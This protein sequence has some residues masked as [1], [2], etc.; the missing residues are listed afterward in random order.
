MA[1]SS[2]ESR[3]QALQEWLFDEGP[4]KRHI[5]PFHEAAGSNPRDAFDD[6]EY[7]KRQGHA[8]VE[9]H[10]GGVNYAELTV[11]G[12]VHVEQL[13]ERRADLPMRNQAC[14]REI[15][16]WLY[17]IGARGESG[18]SPTWEE[19]CLDPQADYL[20]SSFTPEEVEENAGWLYD[21]KLIDGPTVDA[22]LGPI[23]PHLTIRGIDS[24]ERATGDP[25][26][27]TRGALSSPPTR[28]THINV[29]GGYVQ[30]STG[31]H[32]TQQ[33]SVRT[34][35][36][37]IDT[38]LEGV[39]RFVDDLGVDELSELRQLKADAL[40]ELQSEPPSSDA[41][42]RFGDR[43]KALVSKSADLAGAAVISSATTDAVNQA[44]HLVQRLVGG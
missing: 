41:A 26:A 24:V 3:R 33:L 10:G 34:E 36:E 44:V 15:L 16:R 30:I 12:R 43:V 1:L 22:H 35:I 21:H 14:R 25:Q 5:N 17:D 37:R 6:L 2:D 8:R 38:L 39:L 29:H 7:L 13:R 28:D 42:Q 19:F 18:H 11:D 32:S 40:V 23:R 20:G 27:F 9:H 31:D 4:G